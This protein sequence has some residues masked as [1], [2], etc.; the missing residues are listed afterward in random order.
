MKQTR[1]KVNKTKKV[2]EVVAQSIA[3]RVLIE[4]VISE[5]A[6]IAAELNKYIFKVATTAT[7]SQIKTAIEELYKVKVLAV[8]TV[9][10][11]RKLVSYGRTPGFRAASKKAVVTLKAGDSIELFKGV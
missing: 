3:Y 9:N 7:K 6:T 11:R 10:V 2:K 4:P 5:A 8:N 1:K